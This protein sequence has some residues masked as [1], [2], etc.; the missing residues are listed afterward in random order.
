MSC[1]RVF[2]SPLL[3]VC[4]CVG[5]RIVARA[6][7]EFSVARTVRSWQTQWRTKRSNMISWG[8]EQRFNTVSI[9]REVTLNVA[10]IMPLVVCRLLQFRSKPYCLYHGGAYTHPKRHVYRWSEST[11][12][13]EYWSWR[14]CG[15]EMT[16]MRDV[17]GGDGTRSH[18]EAQREEE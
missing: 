9:T 4:A 2:P 6:S 15:G 13:M 3:C 17:G 1:K 11:F 8:T 18:R 5:L 10:G 16:A 7:I 14:R 12:N